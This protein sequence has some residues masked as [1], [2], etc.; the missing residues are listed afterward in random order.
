MKRILRRLL[1]EAAM[2]LL[3][4]MLIGWK[5]GNMWWGLLSAIIFFI[6]LGIMQDNQT[7]R[8]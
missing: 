2:V 8:H 1:L 3:V 5:L 6:V 4:A 7:P